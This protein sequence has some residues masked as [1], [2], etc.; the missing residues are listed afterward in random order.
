MG[1]RLRVEWAGEQDFGDM[2]R[3]DH[4]LLT[5]GG[6]HWELGNVTKSSWCSAKLLNPLEDANAAKTSLSSLRRSK[7]DQPAQAKLRKHS[8]PRGSVRATVTESTVRPR[9]GPRDGL[10]ITFSSFVG[11]DRK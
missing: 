2:L 3:I 6:K 10:G 1:G 5:K 7:F 9:A 11:A 4:V 8:N